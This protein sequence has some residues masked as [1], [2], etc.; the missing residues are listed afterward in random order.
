MK[1]TLCALLVLVMALSLAAC[2]WN[3][4]S[5]GVAA[6][7]KL[8][9]TVSTDGYASLASAKDTVKAV[10]VGASPPAKPP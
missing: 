6:S 5:Q 9:G 8:S 10:Q 7:A 2:G 3:T 4:D 1:R